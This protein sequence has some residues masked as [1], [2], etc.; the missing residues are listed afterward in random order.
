MSLREPLDYLIPDETAA[1]AH[2][3]FPKSNTIMRMRDHFGSLFFNQDFAHLYHAEGTSAYSPA[4]LALMLIF[5]FAEGLSD[6]Q[7]AS[8]VAARIDWKY[9]L[10]LPLTAPAIDPSLLVDFRARLIDGA[11][12][13]LLFTTLLDRFS[14][15]G[16]LRKRG[17]QRTDAT[18]VLA[19]SRSLGRL[20]CIGE[21]LRQALNALAKAAPSWLRQHVPLSWLTSYAQRFDDYRLPEAK[22]KRTQLA[23]QIGQDGRL[24]L[25]WLAEPQA[26]AGLADLPAVV[27]LRQVWQQQFEQPADAHRLRLR[28]AKQLPPSAELICSPYDAEARYSIKRDT[29]WTGYKVH[30]TESCEP[31]KPNLITD[32]QTS[33]ATR[34]DSVVLPEIQAALVERDL[35][36]AEHLVDSGYVSAANLVSSQE[37]QIDLIGPARGEAGW[38][39]RQEGGLTASQF[40]IDWEAQQ[41]QCPAGKVSRR[42]SE[43]SGRNGQ[44]Q[45]SVLFEA[46]ECRCCELRSRCV[47]S[48]RGA[49][50]MTLLPQTQQQALQAARERQQTEDFTALYSAR[51][52]IEGTIGQGSRIADLHRTRYRGLAKTSLLHILIAT[53]LNFLRVAAWLAERPRAQTRQ[54]AFARLA[55]LP[56]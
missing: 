4:R 2:A 5:Q 35:A 14:Q 56:I 44:A 41:V 10:A 8:A 23:E 27:V 39:A 12:E 47:A 19:A 52:G 38:Q 28:A 49:R 24:L 9:A 42:W 43:S 25:E 26:P 11:A 31:D 53:A 18:Q 55:S 45:I 16:L 54:S 1:V 50:A 51:A 34:P 20:E 46:A 33:V 29:H 36:P 32:V 17:R 30:L 37:Q 22:D 40:V 6:A 15:D 21:T 3:A 48:K 13:L 7:A